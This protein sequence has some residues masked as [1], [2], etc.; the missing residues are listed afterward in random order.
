MHL[1]TAAAGASHVAGGRCGWWRRRSAT[2]ANSGGVGGDAGDAWR[3]RVR[4]AEEATRDGEWCRFAPPQLL[5][6]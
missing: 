2:V 1:W 6:R 4:V 3:C 5:P